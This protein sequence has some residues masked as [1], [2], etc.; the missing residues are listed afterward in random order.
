MSLW[1]QWLKVGDSKGL[2]TPDNSAVTWNQKSLL[3]GHILM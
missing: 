3:I 2:L 1:S